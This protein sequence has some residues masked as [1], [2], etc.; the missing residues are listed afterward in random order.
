MNFSYIDI[1]V[2]EN[3]GVNLGFAMHFVAKPSVILASSCTILVIGLVVAL[4]RFWAHNAFMSG[5]MRAS[6][7]RM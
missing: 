4:D 5:Q 3:D 1:R 6:P 2:N 7:D